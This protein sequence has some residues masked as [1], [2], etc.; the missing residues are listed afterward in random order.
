VAAAKN[1]SGGQ[2]IR[3]RCCDTPKCRT[4]LGTHLRSIRVDMLCPRHL[5]KRF[6]TRQDQTCRFLIHTKHKK[7]AF[8]TSLELFRRNKLFNLLQL[9]L[10]RDTCI[11]FTPFK[12]RQIVAISSLR[13]KQLFRGIITFQVS[14]ARMCQS[15][16]ESGKI[17]IIF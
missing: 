2:R 17:E 15:G 3:W 5:S 14:S 7:N 9:R 12:Q 1:K 13:R 11:Q 6:I 10:I 16:N 8:K 4:R